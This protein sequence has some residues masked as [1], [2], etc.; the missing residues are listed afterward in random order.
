MTIIEDGKAHFAG[1]SQGGALYRRP[2]SRVVKL[3]RL[4][5]VLCLRRDLVHLLFKCAT[6]PSV[7][8]H[9]QRWFEHVSHIYRPFG[10]AIWDQDDRIRRIIDHCNT[11]AAIGGLLA[12]TYGRSRDLCSAEAYGGPY[13]VTIDETWWLA[14]EGLTILNLHAAGRR[15]F[16]AAL[17]LASESGG[18]VVYC[19]GLQGSSDLGQDEIKALTRDAYGI[20]PRDFMVICLQVF[21]SAISARALF[22]VSDQYR[23]TR[24]SYFDA[25]PAQ[26]GGLNYDEVWTDR[27][28]ERHDAVWFQ[29]PV[30]FSKRA[31]TH[32]PVRKRSMYRRRYEM[33][34]GLSK[35][36]T[37][38]LI[39][40]GCTLCTSVSDLG[41]QGELGDS[42]V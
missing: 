1:S 32:I 41:R 35:E 26:A 4:M 5:S 33:L 22:G 8:S 2:R 9:P 31:M 14:S 39:K 12:P 16:S 19:C 42:K 29:L 6:A 30:P 7:I 40:S 3:Y 13:S 24:S 38:A 20:R 27:S 37:S 36:M 28:A 17:V 15:A 34:D 18:L 25:A 10:C 11:V 21:A 23:F